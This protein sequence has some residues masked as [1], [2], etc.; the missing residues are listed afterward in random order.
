[1]VSKMKKSEKSRNW[2]KVLVFT[3]KRSLE[4][5]GG[6]R[7]TPGPPIFKSFGVDLDAAL[8][9]LLVK[10]TT[11]KVSENPPAQKNG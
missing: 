3:K 2:G 7:T 1:M 9:I 10:I 8:R 4:I 6:R 5:A 11:K